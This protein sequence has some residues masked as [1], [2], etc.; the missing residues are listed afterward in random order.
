MIVGTSGCGKSTLFYVLMR[1]LYPLKGNIFIQG[2]NYDDLAE[3]SIREHFAVAFQ[4]H[5][6]L[7]Y[8]YVIILKCFMKI[9][10]MKKYI[11]P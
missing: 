10:L 2:K 6:I 1:L 5:H 8:L 4:E 11:N 7:I 9:S 3:K